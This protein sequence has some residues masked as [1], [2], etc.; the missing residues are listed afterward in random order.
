M[1]TIWNELYND[2]II[3][4][5]SLLLIQCIYIY[6]F[7][8]PLPLYFILTL[9]SYLRQHDQMK[10]PLYNISGKL[11]FIRFVFNFTLNVHMKTTVNMSSF[12]EI[13]I[14]FLF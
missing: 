14:N 11:P 10:I 7:V 5:D 12:A 2:A 13:E 6:I 4:A 8:F 9:C 3:Y 1:Y